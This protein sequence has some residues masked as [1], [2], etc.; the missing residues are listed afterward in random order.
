MT[1]TLVTLAVT[2]PLLWLVADLVREWR[3]KRQV[4][5]WTAPFVKPRI[6]R[7]GGRQ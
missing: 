4:A 2:G 1:R 6:P 5:V 7:G 3:E